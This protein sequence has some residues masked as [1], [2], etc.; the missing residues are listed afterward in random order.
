[1]ANPSQRL[2]PNKVKSPVP[3][4]EDW[5]GLLTCHGENQESQGCFHQGCHL[6]L[7]SSAA[8]TRKLADEEYFP[9]FPLLCA[10]FAVSKVWN[11]KKRRKKMNRVDYSGFIASGEWGFGTLRR[12]PIAVRTERWRGWMLSARAHRLYR[13]SWSCDYA[14]WKPAV[15]IRVPLTN[16]AFFGKVSWGA[17]GNTSIPLSPKQP[18]LR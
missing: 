2:K 9:R 8:H 16:S 11:R 15:E 14:Q 5:K 17:S 7:P 10:R 3:F 1:M 13:W 4:R 18:F 12:I 6:F